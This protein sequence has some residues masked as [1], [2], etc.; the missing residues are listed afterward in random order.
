MLTRRQFHS[1]TAAG[2]AV[3]LSAGSIA[4]A[5]T[6]ATKRTFVFAHGSWHGGWCFN[7]VAQRLTSA[8][9]AVFAP[10][11]TGMGDRAHL[12]SKAITIDT[13]V[14]D[15]VNVIEAEELSNVIL[16]GHSFGGVPITGVAEK[17]PT[18]L[19]H[20]VYLDAVVLESGKHSFSVYPPEDAAARIKA[21]EAATGGLAVP[22]PAKLPPVWG[23]VEGSE[24]YRW[25]LRRLTPH[26]LQTYLTALQLT[27]PV[28][29]G[30]PKTYIE[31]TAPAHPGLEGSKKLV[32]AQE[33]W[34][35]LQIAAPHDA[36]ITHPDELTKMLVAIAA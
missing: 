25:V 20:L 8:G 33:G 24:D 1:T 34:Q 31:C 18:R 12:I 21:A 3:V 30:V 4:R 35:W 19:R 5:Q 13:F 36:M 28:G 32:R 6:A 10:S 27:K 15:L 17:I 7:R 2:A 22:V 9:H 29:N 11:Y 16:V 26:P 14:T 23:L